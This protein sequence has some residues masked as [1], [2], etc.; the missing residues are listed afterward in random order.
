MNPD[1]T[2]FTNVYDLDRYKASK[3]GLPKQEA[4]KASKMDSLDLRLAT[5]SD[6]LRGRKYE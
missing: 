5:T 1:K 6:V 2:Q 4:I 3:P